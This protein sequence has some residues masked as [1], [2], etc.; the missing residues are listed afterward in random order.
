MAMVSVSKLALFIIV[1]SLSGGIS[2]PVRLIVPLSE[3][4][5]VWVR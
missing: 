2:S 4:M 3:T 5:T 1:W